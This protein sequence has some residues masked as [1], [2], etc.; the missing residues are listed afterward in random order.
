MHHPKTK[1]ILSQKVITSCL[2]TSIVVNTILYILITYKLSQSSQ[3][4]NISTSVPLQRSTQTIEQ[5]HTQS[6]CA[7]TILYY[8]ATSSLIWLIIIFWKKRRRKVAALLDIFTAIIILIIL[9]FNV[10][11]C[12]TTTTSIIAKSINNDFNI[13]MI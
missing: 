7:S 1:T 10:H 9:Q 11:Q 3:T 8:Y 2:R 12:T 13:G 4:S 5:P 6:S